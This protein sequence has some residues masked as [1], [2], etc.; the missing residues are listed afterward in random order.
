MEMFATFKIRELISW[1]SWWLSHPI[2]KICASQIGSF[3]QGKRG[4]NKKHWKSPDYNSWNH[5]A[6]NSGTFEV[7]WT[8]GISSSSNVSNWLK[9][10]NNYDLW[11]ANWLGRL[12]PDQTAVLLSLVSNSKK[13]SLMIAQKINIYPWGFVQVLE[14]RNDNKFLSSRYYWHPS[15]SSSS[16]EINKWS[17]RNSTHS[18]QLTP[19][20]CL[21]SNFKT[22]GN[23][24][25]GF[26]PP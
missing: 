4:E 5:W 22:L 26:V 3:P 14:E 12:E 9:I 17:L 11:I 18:K 6:P 23:H 16:L 1:A 24:P 10:S 19:V 15:F 2:W 13:K 8:V 21:K 25:N 7:T 20:N